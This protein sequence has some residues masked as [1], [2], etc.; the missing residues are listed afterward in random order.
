MFFCCSMQFFLIHPKRIKVSIMETQKEI[1]DKVITSEK[2][3]VPSATKLTPLE[4]NNIKLDI[5]HTVLTP[6]YL[7]ELISKEN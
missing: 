2:N 7:E 4:L 5:R 1:L 3:I 6:D